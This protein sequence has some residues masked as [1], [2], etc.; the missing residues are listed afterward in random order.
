M[1]SAADEMDRGMAETSLQPANE[2]AADVVYHVPSTRSSAKR[3]TTISISKPSGS[4]L[5]I[6]LYDTFLTREVVVEQAQASSALKV[7]DVILFVNGFE[8]IDAPQTAELIKEASELRLTV[9]RAASSTLAAQFGTDFT[10]AWQAAGC[11]GWVRWVLLCCAAFFLLPLAV[12]TVFFH[13]QATSSEHEAKQLRMEKYKLTSALSSERF[14]SNVTRQSMQAKASSLLSD[15][16]RLEARMRH[17][18]SQLTDALSRIRAM[19]AENATLTAHRS[20]LNAELTQLKFELEAE[21]AS[22]KAGK[23]ELEAE[24]KQ[25]E[26]TQKEVART[27]DALGQERNLS[28]VR[29]AAA[30]AALHHERSVANKKKA[31]VSK[32][33]G[34]G[35]AIRD[36]LA[37]L[38]TLEAAVNAALGTAFQELETSQAETTPSPPPA[39]PPPS[40]PPL[41]ARRDVALE[42]KMHDKLVAQRLAESRKKPQGRR[43]RRRRRR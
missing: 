25:V 23:Q 7:G 13:S 3:T 11:T 17:G 37:K 34:H 5:S 12:G 8:A 28:A 33:V 26:A 32:Q 38:A 42:K 15:K 35:T 27:S 20:Q 31:L 21:R 24:K 6:L 1:K 40:P 2:A 36:T 39:L 43:E 14:V 22:R 10:T 41:V 29:Q 18:S 30:E 16:E 4:G 9:R 19:E